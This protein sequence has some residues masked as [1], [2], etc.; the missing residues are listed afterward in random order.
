MP[1][2][3]S[4]EPASPKGA[5]ATDAYWRL[6]TDEVIS[7]LEVL[8]QAFDASGGTHAGVAGQFGRD[9]DRHEPDGPMARRS[10][11]PLTRRTLRQIPLRTR[12]REWVTRNA[13]IGGHDKAVHRWARHPF[14]RGIRLV[15]WRCACRSRCR[16][17]VVSRQSPQPTVRPRGDGAMGAD[18]GT[19]L[20]LAAR[21]GGRRRPVAGS[22]HVA[23]RHDAF[24]AY[25]DYMET[26]AFL[27][28]V[29]ELLALADDELTAVMCSESVWWRCHRRLLADHLVLVRGVTVVHLMHDGRLTPHDPTD[30]VRLA[31]SGALVYDL[32]AT[33]PP[34]VI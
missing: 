34:S 18:R 13:W 8:R 16:Y 14:R 6:V 10:G 31:D 27:A 19:R 30:G 20:P 1:T 24:R 21:P 3:A 2:T 11:A 4:S 33:P 17:P 9:L 7:V 22:K 15:A 23:L 29:D 5:T 32:V 25:A 12:L 26:P 28:G